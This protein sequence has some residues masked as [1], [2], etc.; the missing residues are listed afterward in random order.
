[1][2]PVDYLKLC[3]RI[4]EIIRSTAEPTGCTCSDW[5]Q[6]PNPVYDQLKEGFVLQEY[7]GSPVRLHTPWGTLDM[8]GS[9]SGHTDPW[10]EKVRERLTLRGLRPLLR[11]C[12]GEAGP[13]HVIEAIDGEPLPAVVEHASRDE[14]MGYEE[15]RAAWNTTVEALLAEGGACPWRK[16][17][18]Y[19]EDGKPIA[20]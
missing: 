10:V 19:D 4:R 15:T 18:V 12:S 20:S 7:Y 5:T 9:S 1:M 11:T 3:I 6:A 16:H 13:W 2:L 8:V 17:T 14:Y